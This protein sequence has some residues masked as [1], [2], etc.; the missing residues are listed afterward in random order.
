VDSTDIRILDC[1]VSDSRMTPRRIAK[2][3]RKTAPTVATRIRKMTDQSIIVGYTTIVDFEKI[4]HAMTVIIGL[5]MTKNDA[6]AVEKKINELPNVCCAYRVTG[7]PDIVIIGKFRSKQELSDFREKLLSFNSV[8]R[9]HCQMA[10]TTIK[11]DFKSAW[12]V[13]KSAQI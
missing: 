5:R 1:L 8:K 10:L 4:G 6:L 9:A 7:S 11:E 12:N 13:F 3:V 2:E